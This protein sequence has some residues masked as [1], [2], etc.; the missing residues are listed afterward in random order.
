V[1]SSTIVMIAFAV[2]FGLLAVFI[3]QSWLNSQAEMRMKSLEANKKPIATRT[4]V[5]AAKPLRFG[6]ELSSGALREIPW[7][8]Q[9]IPAGAFATVADLTKEGRRVVLSPIEAN[10][11]ILGW[12]ITGPG[13]RATLSAML[14]D[15]LKAVTIRVNDVEGVAGF[16]LPGDYVD[17]ALT[18]QNEKIAATS[19]II[20]QSA[21]V[22]AIDQMADER[23]DK[24]SVVKAVTL[25]V[26]TA[27]AQKISLAASIGTMSLILRK[28]GEANAEFT[29]RIT[30]TDLSA[31]SAP[32]AKDIPVNTNVTTVSVT[33][34]A[35]RQD[36]SVPIEG[37]ETVGHASGEVK[38]KRK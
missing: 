34:A 36:Y 23:S 6:G 26:D 11:P 20:L 8:E 15:G 25:E 18:R 10:E 30:A 22:L 33:R 28:A 29:R 19:D 37:K 12:K 27:G 14:R 31:P 17:V 38:S 7:P 13:Q 3:A 4:I 24:P 16:V 32:V 2:V 1:R 9:A 35:T 5:V 21:R